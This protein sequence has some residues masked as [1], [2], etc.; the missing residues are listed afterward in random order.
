MTHSVDIST[1]SIYRKH[2]VHSGCYDNQNAN[3]MQAHQTM[4][5]VNFRSFV[6]VM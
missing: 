1:D 2:C 3:Y 5:H 4:L 6:A